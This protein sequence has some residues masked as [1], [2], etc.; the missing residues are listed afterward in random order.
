MAMAM[1]MA[2]PA[3]AV[4]AVVAGVGDGGVL[5][6]LLLRLHCSGCWHF[7]SMLAW[8]AFLPFVRS[9]VCVPDPVHWIA[10]HSG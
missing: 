8:E 5:L 2:A 1:T 7:Y 9:L 4:V 10:L 6:P 3:V